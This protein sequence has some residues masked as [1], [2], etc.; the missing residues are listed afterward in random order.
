MEAKHAG[1]LPFIFIPGDKKNLRIKIT[2]QDIRYIEANANYIKIFTESKQY[3]TYLSLGDILILLG[4]IYFVR[5]HKS[6]IV[7]MQKI[8]SIDAVSIYM[9]C[10]VL[11]PIGSAFKEGFLRRIF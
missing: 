7:N 10:G 1:C 8:S 11:I 2:K 6:Y 9:E 3:M 5:V 4:D